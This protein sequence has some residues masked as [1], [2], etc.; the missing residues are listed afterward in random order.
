MRLIR[1]TGSKNERRNKEETMLH[2]CMKKEQRETVMH[3]AKLMREAAENYLLAP[4]AVRKYYL[5]LYC[6]LLKKYGEQ[7]REKG[8]SDMLDYPHG[9]DQ[10]VSGCG[11]HFFSSEQQSDRSLPGNGRKKKRMVR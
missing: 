2:G 6:G 5:S 11:K 9:T 4:M 8:L 10:S 7:L 3:E 1:R